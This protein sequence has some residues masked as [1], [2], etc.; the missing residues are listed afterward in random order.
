[1]TGKKSIK[2]CDFLRFMGGRSGGSK[3]TG[4]NCRDIIQETKLQYAMELLDNSELSIYHIAEECG[5]SSPS[6]FFRVFREKYG[7]TPNEYRVNKV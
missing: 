4:R 1:M 6:H 3:H 7:I 2:I 5:Y